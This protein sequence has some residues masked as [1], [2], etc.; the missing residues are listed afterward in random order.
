MNNQITYSN[1]NKIIK[2]IIIGLVVLGASRY[3][4]SEK[5]SLENSLLIGAVASITFALI[6]MLSPSVKIESS[7]K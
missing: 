3:L 4:P 6:D 1:N 7:K 2:Y 5:I